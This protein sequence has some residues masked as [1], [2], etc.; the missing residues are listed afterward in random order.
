MST[1]CSELHQL[2]NHLPHFVFPYETKSIPQNGIYVMFER[3]EKAHGNDR[4]VYVGSHQ[5]D[6]RLEKRLNEHF[7]I[8]NKDRSILRKNI[9]RALLNKRDDPFLEQW[10]LNLT[11]RKARELYK[12]QVDMQKQAHIESEVTKIIRSNFS[13]CVIP[14]QGKENRKHYKV[15]LIASIAQCHQCGPSKNWMGRFSTNEKIRESGLWNI[16]YLSHEPFQSSDLEILKQR[17]HI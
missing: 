13:F 9:G 1:I 15:G 17:V 5:G 2:F 16:H 7:I 11:S 3:K 14:I 6:N 10:E 4:I 8:E 12:G